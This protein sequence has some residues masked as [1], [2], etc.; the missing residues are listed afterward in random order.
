MKYLTK[1]HFIQAQFCPTSLYY[2]S[3]RALYK[4]SNLE[5][6]LISALAEGGLQVGSFAR[7]LFEGTH[8]STLDTEQA[9]AETE[10]QLSKNE[11]ILFEPA[12]LWNRML[13]RVDVLIKRGEHVEVLEVKAKSCRGGSEEQF[14][15][16][17]GQ[18]LRKW[19]PYL[20]DAAFQHHV[21][22]NRRPQWAVS[23]SLLLVDKSSSCPADGLHQK[24]LLGRLPDGRAACQ[25]TKPLTDEEES[26]DILVRVP[27]EAVMHELT[28]SPGYGPGG[29][30]LLS[31]WAEFLVKRH[32]AGERIWTPLHKGCAHCPFR[33]RS[34]T[35]GEGVRSGFD[36]CW[37]H[38]ANFTDEDFLNPTA[39]E[40]WNARAKGDWLAAGRTRMKDLSI[41]DFPH[42]ITTPGAMEAQERRWIQVRKAV[43]R[44]DTMELRQGLAEE[45]ASWRYPLHFIDFETM[46]PAIPMHAGSKPYEMLAFQFSHHMVH[47]DGRVEHAGEFI[48]DRLG[49]FPNFEFVRNLRDELEGDRGTVFR[50]HNHEN[51]VLRTIRKQLLDDT[52][53]EDSPVLVSF[54]EGI[55]QPGSKEATELTA[56]SRNMVDMHR[57][58][59]NYYYDPDTGGSN[60]IKKVLPAVLRR[61]D[62][63]R[64]RY[65]QPVYG[66]KGE[67]PSRNFSGITWYVERE[68][69]VIDPYELLPPLFPELSRHDQLLLLHREEDGEDSAIRH[70]GAAMT[71]FARMQYCEMSQAERDILRAQLLQYCE[72]DTL[73]MVMIFEAWREWLLPQGSAAPG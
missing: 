25:L 73:A 37:R 10:E 53:I 29:E 42:E 69:G 47:A 26:S 2:S 19:R 48:D 39:L 34:I 71:A 18:V 16:K 28:N 14:L 64:Q 58:V 46:A 24:F 66:A 43:D 20:D 54:I 8:I 41:D 61:S 7:A 55:T 1:S 17:K 70:G 30:W 6:P 40:V 33:P 50:Y 3:R 65:S 15:G 27:L 62:F 44:D 67:I 21:V 49:A 31:D 35:P 68:N 52:T 23:T 51:T 59:R 4:N 11:V 57:L 63:L 22:A 12:F 5:D 38:Q 60:S 36:E 9:L 45:M 56:G 72:L 13:V 32:A